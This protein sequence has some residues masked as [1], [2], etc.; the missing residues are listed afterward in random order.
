MSCL[1]K[2][3]LRRLSR[4]PR[5]ELAL[6]LALPRQAL[7]RPRARCNTHTHEHHARV[8]SGGKEIAGQTCHPLLTPAVT[9]AVAASALCS[10]RWH[11][12]CKRNET[13]NQ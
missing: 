13:A 4:L 9:A 10:R 6:L 11:A 5:A 8:M 12:R 3:P 2:Q 7:H 1:A